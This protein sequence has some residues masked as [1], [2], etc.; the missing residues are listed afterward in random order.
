MKGQGEYVP[1]KNGKERAFTEDT[2]FL[3]RLWYLGKYKGCEAMKVLTIPQIA[4][5]LRR[6]EKNVR[7]ALGRYA[8]IEKK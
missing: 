8:E 1:V 7:M 2:V 4:R 3:V 5:V 6:S